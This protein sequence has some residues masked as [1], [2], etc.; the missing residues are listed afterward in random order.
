MAKMLKKLFTFLSVFCLVSLAG[1][2]V[3]LVFNTYNT[4][5]TLAF[6]IP[7]TDDAIK[8]SVI[9]Q[10]KQQEEHGMGKTGAKEE[11]NNKI[12]EDDN[13]LKKK[14]NSDNSREKQEKPEN[15]E[16]EQETSKNTGKPCPNVPPNL[17]GALDVNY[18]VKH[19]MDDAKKVAGASLREGGR[20]KPKECVAL[21]KVGE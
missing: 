20:Y 4:N 3:M 17:V 6:F 15:P 18:N 10:I 21:Q 5:K 2:V 16:K 7:T 19:T 1:Y 14:G 9:S 13:M 11:N 12:K 8:A